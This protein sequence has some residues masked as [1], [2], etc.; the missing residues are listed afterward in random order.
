MTSIFIFFV[1]EKC[2]FTASSITIA[3]VD[4]ESCNRIILVRNF[5]I[6]Y[7]RYLKEIYHA[8]DIISSYRSAL[9]NRSDEGKTGSS[10]K[11]NQGDFLLIC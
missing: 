3:I 4:R 11:K 9:I 1:K 10:F 8:I 7:Q 6:Q 2:L 5:N